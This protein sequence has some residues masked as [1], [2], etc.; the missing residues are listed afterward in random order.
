MARVKKT[1]TGSEY[2]VRNEKTGKLYGE[3]NKKSKAKKR[4]K[5]VKK[6]KY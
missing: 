1:K 3:F 5:K 4:A 2:R 6:R